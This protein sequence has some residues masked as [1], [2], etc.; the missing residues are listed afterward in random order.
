MRCIQFIALSLI[1]A[2]C[3]AFSTRTPETPDENSQVLEPATT[4]EVL[5]SNFIESIQTQNTN[6]YSQCFEPSSA[7][8]RFTPASDAESVLGTVFQTWTVQQELAW[9]DR[10]VNESELGFSPVL[11]IATD[12]LTIGGTQSAVLESEYQFVTGSTSV[13]NTDTVAGT[14]YLTLSS[15]T[16]GLWYITEWR[17]E[18]TVIERSS[19]SMLKGALSN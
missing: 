2:G 13:S 16:D 10:W 5:L 6:A 18:N 15:S 9:F 11:S 3:D 4:A 1:I 12:E 7:S 14:M 17:D 8:Y 19:W